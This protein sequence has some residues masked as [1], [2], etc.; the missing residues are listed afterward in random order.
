V[1]HNLPRFLWLHG[2][3]L[4]D[5]L[6]GSMLIIPDVIDLLIRR[7]NRLDAANKKIP[8]LRW[9]HFFESSFSVSLK[10]FRITY[11][12]DLVAIKCLFCAA[13]AK[14]KRHGTRKM[15]ICS[16]SIY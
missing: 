8:T 13:D 4:K 1:E 6:L 12:F 10:L 11:F 3:E 2:K 5:N 14:Y 9:R 16:Q 7:F 15:S